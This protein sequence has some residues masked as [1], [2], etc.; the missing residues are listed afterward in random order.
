ML[1]YLSGSIWASLAQTLVNTV[2]VVGWQ[3]PSNLEY[4][5][6]GLKK[7]AEYYEQIGFTTKLR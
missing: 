3:Q 2:N 1:T 7:F 4:I 6:A 5:E